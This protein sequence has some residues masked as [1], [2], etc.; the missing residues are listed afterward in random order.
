[1]PELPEV[2][3]VRRILSAEIGGQPIRS[4]RVTHL[5]MLRR[6]PVGTDF[7]DR[8]RGRRVTGVDRHGKF[9]LSRL[10]G[11]VTW[12]MHLGMSGRVELVDPDH[13]AVPHTHVRVGIGASEV[14]LIDPR[15]FGFTAAVTTHEL[16]TFEQH[17]GP[18][19]FLELPSAAALAGSLRGRRASVK[20]LLLDQRIIAGLGNIYTDEILFRAGIR[21]LRS[22]GSLA[23]TEIGRLHDA[24]G[25]VLDEALRNGG[26]TLND[27]AFL[28][29]DG[30]AA[31]D[32]DRLSVYGRQGAPCRKCGNPIRRSMVVGRSTFWC[33]TCQK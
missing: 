27:L 12:V 31:G 16:R 14:R 13:H 15:T 10:D 23:R 2:E 7:V 19:A 1:M 30:R 18:D 26:T 25:P 17:L 32:L 22:A 9:L 11:G 28:L 20:A 24:I 8:M 6:Q 5:R 4:V 3:T 21:G 33:P 29:P